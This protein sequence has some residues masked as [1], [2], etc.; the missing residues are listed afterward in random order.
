MIGAAVIAPARRSR[1]LQRVDNTAAPNPARY[2]HLWPRARGGGAQS[3]AEPNHSEPDAARAERYQE[4][5]VEIES[6][7][8]LEQRASAAAI[9]AATGTN[10]GDDAIGAIMAKY[11]KD[12]N[13]KFD[14]G[15]VRDPPPPAPPCPCPGHDVVLCC[16]LCLVF[17]SPYKELNNSHVRRRGRALQASRTLSRRL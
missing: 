7:P 2:G 8:T 6:A 11:D 1:L 12:K 16:S 10:Y 13:G 5:H 17:C 3:P 9:A 14:L 15:E 4:M